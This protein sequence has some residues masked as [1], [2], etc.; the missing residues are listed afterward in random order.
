[1]KCGRSRNATSGDGRHRA[2]ASLT[3]MATAGRMGKKSGLG[4]YDWSGPEPVVAKVN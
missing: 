1:M 4:F 2:P 3:R